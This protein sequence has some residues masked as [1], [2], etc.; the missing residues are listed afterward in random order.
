MHIIIFCLELPL[1]V[2]LL[3]SHTVQVGLWKCLLCQTL[4]SKCIRYL[5]ISSFT[6]QGHKHECCCTSVFYWI[7]W[8]CAT[9]STLVTG[10]VYSILLACICI[11]TNAFSTW[12]WQHEC[13]GFCDHMKLCMAVCVCECTHVHSVQWEQQTLCD[14][15]I[16]KCMLGWFWLKSLFPQLL[17]KHSSV[18][19]CRQLHSV[20]LS[21]GDRQ[22]R[23]TDSNVWK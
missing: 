12:L 10:C 1:L 3:L 21:D 22:N 11:L 9:G 23:E 15:L 7:F 18:S 16:K 14:P 6:A 13:I 5:H 8:L 19:L 2:R 20:T 4:I 17:V